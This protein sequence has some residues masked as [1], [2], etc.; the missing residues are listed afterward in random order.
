[1]KWSDKNSEIL[2]RA[3]E[4]Y[5]FYFGD[6][7]Y[8]DCA[9]SKIS[10]KMPKAHL[11]W[12]ARAV[13]I[14][15]NK[16]HFDCFE[17][18]AL[19]LNSI[20][21][22]YDMIKAFDKVKRDVLIAGCGFL[23]LA[24]DKVMPFT[25]EEA[26]GTYSWYEQNLK[27]GYAIFARSSED[28]LR[29]ARPDAYV[30]YSPTRTILYEEKTEKTS[31]NSTGR[32]LIG[33]LTHN[34]TTKRPFGRSVL[35]RPVRDSILDASRTTRQAMVAA[36]Y[37]N[38]KV[39]VIL[40][41]DVDT[42]I[43]K[44]ESRTGDILKVGVNADGQIPKVGEFAQHA[45]APF[46]ETILIAAN[47]FCAGTKLGLVNLGMTT[48][49]PQSNEALEIVNDDLKD[50]ILAWQEELGNQLKYFAVTLYMYDNNIKEID[51][52]LQ[53]KINA[54][55]PVWKPVYEADVSK[56][57]D[58]LTK[59]AQNVPDIVKARSIWRNLGLSS[60]EIDAV[61]ASTADQEL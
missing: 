31:S 42:S 34:S 23:A 54:T 28:K 55:L 35:S 38:T 36:Y 7:D 25:A 9:N 61:I 27:D 21:Q 14:R 10:D 1:M 13:D 4:K 53:A 19:S 59:I 39:D 17:N 3:A 33:L 43:D 49:A 30:D 50:D 20:L 46:K 12:A 11:G 58:G 22:K 2:K 32:P 24:D 52:N 41:A 56:F 51:S 60:E 44:V 40:G 37:Y 57:G 18:D 16:T 6:Y 45:M 8:H 15:S 29:A 26:T 47:N 5:K 48:D